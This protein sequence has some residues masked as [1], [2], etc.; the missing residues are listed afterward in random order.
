MDN[1]IYFKS[2]K[3]HP[4]GPG[5]SVNYNLYYG[6]DHI[7]YIQ[8]TSYYNYDIDETVYKYIQNNQSTIN[9]FLTSNNSQKNAP[10]SATPSN[11]NLYQST[12]DKD[13]NENYKLTF[14]NDGVDWIENESTKAEVK[15][16]ANFNGP[17]FKL[18]GTVGPNYGMFKY[19]ISTKITSDQQIEQVILDWKDVDCFSSSVVSGTTLLNLTDLGYEEHI[20]EIETLYDKNVLSS[21]NNI[22]IKEIQFL[23]NYN[24]SLGEES[25][26]PDLSFISI[27]G[28]K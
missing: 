25:I 21:G 18:I 13:S 12:I 4:I 1:I 15:V 2:A 23:K 11:V 26:N 14:F 22:L 5:N 28:V 20:I 10:L 9:Y 17:K 19:R 6:R 24:I 27:G 8:P 3:E 16:I 7:K